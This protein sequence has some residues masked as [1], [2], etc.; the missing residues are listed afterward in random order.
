MPRKTTAARIAYVAAFVV[1]ALTLVPV[2]LAGKGGGGSGGGGTTAGGGHKGGGGGTGTTYTGSFV[3]NNPLMVTDTGTAGVSFGDAVTFS[4]TDTATYY[5]VRVDCSQNGV[6][7]WTQT[8]GFYVGWMW[9]T[10]YWLTGGSWTSGAA[11]CTATL[12][13]QNADGTNTQTQASMSFKVAA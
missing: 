13:S 1:L 2:A 8:E 5:G 10:T 3:G 11:T 12:F 9:G 6:Q 7:V 4:V